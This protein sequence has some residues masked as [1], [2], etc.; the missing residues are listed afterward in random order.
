MPDELVEDVD[1]QEEVSIREIP[2]SDIMDDIQQGFMLN[3]YSN[4]RLENNQLNTAFG[5]LGN[6]MVK[7]LKDYR[8]E[9][10]RTAIPIIPD[11]FNPRT[12]YNL[13]ITKPLKGQK[14]PEMVIVEYILENEEYNAD[15]DFSN[16]TG[17]IRTYS[18]NGEIINDIRMIDGKQAT[19]ANNR[20]ENICG[21]EYEWKSATICPGPTDDYCNTQYYWDAIPIDCAG[22]PEID[23]GGPGSSGGTPMNPS[24]DYDYYY[25]SISIDDYSN[26]SWN[27]ET[28]N[29]PS[30]IELS[31]GHVV[32]IDFGFTNDGVNANQPVAKRL[33][34]CLIFALESCASE[35]G[36]NRIYIKA[37][38]NGVHGQNSNH[39]RGLAI[40][41]SRINNEYIMNLG[42]NSQV[43]A[44][45]LALETFPFIR[46]NFG[47]FLK[48]KLN[49]PFNQV[50]DHQTHIHFSVNGN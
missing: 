22:T 27:G 5:K 11:E 13:V 38:T 20:T 44:L 34:D 12:F 1:K 14:A 49:A 29:I 4:Y 37:T 3:G 24:V 45:Q 26:S 21:Y 9:I 35:N 31:N 42:A 28:V 47:P 30:Q 39:Y 25:G 18:L 15:F 7:E 10:V 19:I 41:L 40:D 6:G 2:F 8:F 48:N 43:A 36:I 17:Y 50:Q 16:Y 33:L 23:G 46:E 32:N